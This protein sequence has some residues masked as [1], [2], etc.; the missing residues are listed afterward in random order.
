M[1]KKNTES[2]LAIDLIGWGL[3]FFCLYQAYLGVS[4]MSVLGFG[5]RG[6]SE[7]VQVPFD[8][9]PILY[10]LYMGVYLF[11]GVKGF[12]AFLRWLRGEG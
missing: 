3:V 4:T 11:I 8:Q 1:N 6:T 7:S 2:N 5:A 10:T 12:F 9:H